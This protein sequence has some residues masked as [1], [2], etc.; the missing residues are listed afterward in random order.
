LKQ[1]IAVF[2]EK[3]PAALP[4]MLWMAD[5]CILFFLLVAPENSAGVHLKALARLSPAAQ[6][7]GFRQKLMSV[8]ECGT[9]LIRLLLKKMKAAAPER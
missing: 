8:A 7:N 4:S 5:R 1:L 3:R 6:R 9:A 2:R